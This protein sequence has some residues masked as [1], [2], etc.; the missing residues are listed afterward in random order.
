LPSA[1]DQIAGPS[2]QERDRIRTTLD[3]VHTGANWGGDKVLE[4]WLLEHRMKAERLASERLAH[5]TWALAAVT[6]LLVLAT[7]AL[8]IAT[9]HLE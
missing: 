2:Q 8:V 6:A 7:V 9:F 1:V 3:Q 5:A 4:I